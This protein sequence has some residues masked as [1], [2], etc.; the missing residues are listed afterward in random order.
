MRPEIVS[1]CLH[2]NLAVLSFLAFTYHLEDSKK[3]EKNRFKKRTK[4]ESRKPLLKKELLIIDYYV[5]IIT[6]I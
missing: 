5:P 1:K 4:K 2:L 6:I 3:E